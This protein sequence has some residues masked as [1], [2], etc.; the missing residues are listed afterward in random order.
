MELLLPTSIA[1]YFYKLR[2]YLLSVFLALK[3]WELS[4]SMV[5]WV[6]EASHGSCMACW[7]LLKSALVTAGLSGKTANKKRP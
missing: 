3:W 7:K 6:V 4:L 5:T 2:F 1:I